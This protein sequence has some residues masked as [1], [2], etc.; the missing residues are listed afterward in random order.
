MNDGYVNFE[1]QA[2]TM[3]LYALKVHF[4]S[5]TEVTRLLLSPYCKWDIFY[6]LGNTTQSNYQ[7]QKKNDILST[8]LHKFSVCGHDI[9]PFSWT[10]ISPSLSSSARRSLSTCSQ[11][12]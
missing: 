1:K 5:L 8:W 12:T 2:T 7:T 9:L 6:V 4:D 11:T 3:S 10:R